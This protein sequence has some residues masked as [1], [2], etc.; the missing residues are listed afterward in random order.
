MTTPLFDTVEIS[1]FLKS[2]FS[3]DRGITKENKNN[4]NNNTVQNQTT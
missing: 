4:N 2:L 3:N 1:I